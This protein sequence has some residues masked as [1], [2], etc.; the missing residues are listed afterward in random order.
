MKSDATFVSRQLKISGPAL[1]VKIER[2][3]QYPVE[4]VLQNIKGG[5]SKISVLVN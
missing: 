5:L 2:F 4:D 3:W 1:S